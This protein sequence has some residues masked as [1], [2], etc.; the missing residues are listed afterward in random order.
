V[1]GTDVFL[2]DA[3]GQKP[4][5]KPAPTTALVHLITRVQAFR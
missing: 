5:A 1:A 2:I 4:P 3:A